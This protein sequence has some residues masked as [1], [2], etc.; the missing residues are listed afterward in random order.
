MTTTIHGISIKQKINNYTD[1]ETTMTRRIL[2]NSWNGQYA[3]GS[4][5]GQKR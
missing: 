1:S 2:R 4:V 3:I 5:N